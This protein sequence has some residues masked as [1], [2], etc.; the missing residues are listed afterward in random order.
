MR[1]YREYQL[2]AINNFRK[3]KWRG[4]LEMATGTGKTITS[5]SAAKNY[6]QENEHIFLIILVPFTHLA[7]QWEKDCRK[8]GFNQILKC[9]GLKNSWIN[10]LISKVRDFNIG[11]SY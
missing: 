2:E 8:F 5:L 6:M 3:N 9:Y 10:S 1:E 4:I 7:D 11:I